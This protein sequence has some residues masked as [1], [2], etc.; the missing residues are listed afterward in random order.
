M[1]EQY[2][3]LRTSKD[4][5]EKDLKEQLALVKESKASEMDALRF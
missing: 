3:A 2:E 4:Q 5:E 1:K